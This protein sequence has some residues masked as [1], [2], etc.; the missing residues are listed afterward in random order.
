MKSTSQVLKQFQKPVFAIILIAS[1]LLNTTA[2]AQSWIQQGT[3]IDGEAPNDYSGVSVSMPD[4]YT[5]AIGA[6]SND[7]NGEDAGHVRV[8]TWVGSSWVQKGMDIEGETNYDMLGYS[9]SMPD[10][11]TVA[12]GA[13][14]N[15][16]NGINAGHVQ[17]YTWDGNSWIQKGENIEGEAAFDRSGIA[18][19]MPDANTVAIG[20][21][22]NDGNGTD[23]G[24]VRV[25]TW[26]GSSW[27]QKGSDID[28]EAA[29]DRSGIAVSMPDANTVAI[30]AT[31][32]DGNGEDAGHV[33]IYAWDGS[34]WIQKGADIDGEAAGDGSGRSVSMPDANTVA[35][36]ALSNDGNG[37]DA[38]QVRVYT[39]N[40]N[41]WV[42]K[43]TDIDGE[44]AGDWSGTSVS[45]PDANTVA[46][47]ALLNDG[48]GTDAGHVRIYSWDGSSWVQKGA[49]IDGEAAEDLSGVSVSMPDANTVAIGAHWN[50]GSG[51]DAGH[52][53]IYSSCS[54]ITSSFSIAACD[55]YTVPSGD[56]TY[57]TSGIYTDTISNTAG[58]DMVLIIDLTI[59]TVDT[60]I[61][62][63][64]PTLT[65]N[66]TGA[67]YQWLD[68]DNGHTPIPGE[69]NQNF[70]ATTSGNYAVEI[71]QNGCT[72]TSSCITITMVDV[73]E[74]SF[75]QAL[76]VFPNPTT[77]HFSVD[78]GTTY[79]N[80]AISILDLNGKLIS[81]YN[82]SQAQILELELNEP[83]GIYLLRLEAGGQKA[84]IRLAKE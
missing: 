69:T 41:S 26:D 53:R 29:F 74:N 59:I 20:A 77:G 31:G 58:C 34:S 38:G 37:T 16:G 32:N 7:G 64:S 42:Q 24:Q 50:D 54:T 39:W 79:P 72:D 21:I 9:V 18:V 23:A 67:S 65:A 70:T 60:S 14:L 40:G 61:T 19:S 2:L 12:A 82:Y 46:I 43:G 76:K 30:G 25:Y 80:I 52:V 49:D 36:G 5:I 35:I 56:E 71:T 73:V 83:A 55:S 4:A 8:Y 17:I 48:N 27:V 28:G 6:A 33:R 84:L 10:A 78:L 63:N 66:A 15:D 62:N 3:D 11:N 13:L 47:G 45:M 57:T 22:L 81:H 1:M 68:C 51:E 44:A 75:D